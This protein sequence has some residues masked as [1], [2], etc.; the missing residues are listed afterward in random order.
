[1][2]NTIGCMAKLGIY[3]AGIKLLEFITTEC[4]IREFSQSNNRI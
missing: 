4:S 1:M 3:Y 2:Y